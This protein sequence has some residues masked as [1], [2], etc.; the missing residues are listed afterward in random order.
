MP[1]ARKPVVASTAVLLAVIASVWML[2]N[3]VQ[4]LTYAA[5]SGQAQAARNQLAIGDT[6]VK[7]VGDFREAVKS[8]DVREGIRMQVM[9]DGG[10][11]YVF[12]RGNE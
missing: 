12:F 4:R 8:L 10:R 3:M 6:P 1:Y 2:P 7:D 11:R 5:E 9:R